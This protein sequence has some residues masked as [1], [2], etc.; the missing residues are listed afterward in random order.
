MDLSHIE[1]PLNGNALREYISNAKNARESIVEGFL[2]KY[3]STMISADPG[4]GKSTVA[5]QVAVELATGLPVFGVLEVTRPHKIL[6]IQTERSILEFAERLET[7]S[8]IYPINVDNIYVT[9]EYQ[10]LNIMKPDNL[11]LLIRAITRECPELDVVFIDP[12]YS[13]VPGGLKDEGRATIFNNAMN[14]IQKTTNAALYYNHHTVKA[15]HGSDGGAIERDD[16][17]YGS[18]WLKAHVTGSYHLKK[19]DSGVKFI[20]KKDNYNVLHKTIELDYDAETQLCSIPKDEIPAIERVKNF[21]K[22]KKIDGKTFTFNELVLSTGVCT[23]TARKLLMH[24]SIRPLLIVVSASKNRHIY[25]V[26]GGDLS[27]AVH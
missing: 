16:P 1:K 8:K 18:Q 4:L 27:S 22:V 11:D 24:S 19:T 2:Y 5:T 7:I 14:M 12:I 3:T 20:C 15:Q 6:Y 10:K 26:G 9:D 23:R 13:M 21:L 25:R 17:F